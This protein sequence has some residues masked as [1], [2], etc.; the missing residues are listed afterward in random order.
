M[1]LNQYSDMTL[2][3]LV[4]SSSESYDEVINGPFDYNDYG[5]IDRMQSCRAV[6]WRLLGKVSGVKA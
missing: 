6:D 1:G 4:S 3:E 2:E 5:Y